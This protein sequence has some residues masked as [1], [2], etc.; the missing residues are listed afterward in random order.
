MRLGFR[1]VLLVV[2]VVV[3]AGGGGAGGAQSF[4]AC[5]AESPDGVDTENSRLRTLFIGGGKRKND[6]SGVKRE[7]K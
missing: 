1:G 2:V 7:S 4:Q 5:D 6:N 3:A